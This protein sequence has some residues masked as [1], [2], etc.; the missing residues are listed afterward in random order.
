[1]HDLP[2][3]YDAHV[4]GTPHT[5]DLILVAIY[6]IYISTHVA[7]SHDTCDLNVTSLVR[8]PYVISVS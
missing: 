8:K 3:S 6:D 2:I 5:C 4:V 7:A 1:M